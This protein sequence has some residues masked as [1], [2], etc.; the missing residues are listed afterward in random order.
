MKSGTFTRVRYI[1]ISRM[2]L[3]IVSKLTA[4]EKAQFLDQI[5]EW[6]LQLE[7]GQ[8][9]EA[10]QAQSSF[11]DMALRE[12]LPELQEGYAK[13]MQAVTSRKK[14]DTPQIDRRPIADIP[15]TDRIEENRKEK[16]ENR[17]DYVYRDAFGVSQEQ[18]NEIKERMKDLGTDEPDN[19]FWNT[20]FV[21]GYT[22]IDKALNKAEE[23]GCTSLKQITGWISKGID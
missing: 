22:A 5:L 1:R 12:E 21:R 15:P 2:A 10:A 3:E 16:E 11:L 18:R 19:G 9:I 14:A 8:D 13:Y 6:F 4:A 17:E 20:C 23:T 7:N